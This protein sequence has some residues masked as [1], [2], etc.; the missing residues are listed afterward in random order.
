METDV[1][2]LVTATD[3]RIRTA[4]IPGLTINAT[5]ACAGAGAPAT[6]QY[7]GGG[8]THSAPQGMTGGSYAIASQVGAPGANGVGASTVSIDVPPPIAPTVIDSWA[9]VLE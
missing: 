4:V 7:V 6:D 1:S 8:A 9:A 3:S 2:P 5:P